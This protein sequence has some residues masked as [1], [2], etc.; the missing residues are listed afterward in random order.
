MKIRILALFAFALAAFSIHERSGNVSILSLDAYAAAPADAGVVLDAGITP[1]ASIDPE[2]DPGGFLHAL[3]AAARGGQWRLL[4]AALLIG[5]VYLARRFAGK[6]IP[7]LRTDRGG[8]ILTLT[9]G[10]LAGIATALGTAAPFS[11]SLILGGVLTGMTAAGGWV[12]L[13]RLISP[14]DPPLSET[15]DGTLLE[16]DFGKAKK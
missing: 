4:A 5:L 3:F 12:M 10:I 7:Y 15:E 2:A 11:A 13:R 16:P 8:V 6:A 9:L 14:K 1:A